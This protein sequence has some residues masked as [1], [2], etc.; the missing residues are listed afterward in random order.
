MEVL[1]KTSRKFDQTR[2]RLRCQNIPTLAEYVL[3][4][5]D[6]GEIQ[7]CS[8]NQGW[9]SNYYYLGDQ[10]ELASLD[11]TL[12]AEDLYDQ[13]DNEDVREY[14]PRKQESTETP[15]G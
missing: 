8:R 15:Q 7:V 5:Q 9:Q 6:K 2:T 11:I 10:I 1:S 13:V 14:L 3:V 12:A 4:E